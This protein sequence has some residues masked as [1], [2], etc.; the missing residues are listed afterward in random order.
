MSDVS[1][2][3][4]P[5]IHLPTNYGYIAVFLT[6]DCNLKCSY[7][8]NHFHGQQ[9][10]RSCLSADDWIRGLNRLV[11]S[12]NLP[13]TLQGGEPTLHPGFYDIIHSL[14]KDIPIDIL[15]NLQF[16]IDEFIRQVS[17]GR[18]RRNAPYAS[19]RA[20]FHPGVMNYKK[21]RDKVLR[22]LDNDFSVGVW[23]VRHP[24]FVRSIEEAREDFIQH[25]IDFREKEFL[26]EYGG[27]LWGTYRYPDAVSGT[28][29]QKV[30]CKTSE[31]IIGPSGHIY[32]CHSY[33]YNGWPPIGHLLDP[34]FVVQDHYRSCDRFGLCNPCDVKIKTN[35][36]QQ[37]GHTSVNIRIPGE[38]ISLG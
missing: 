6:L 3:K 37:Y 21:L 34:D 12:T 9:K 32:P 16:D 18:I 24:A 15:T 28:V 33:L 31:L 8:I 35:R 4:P 29:S 1:N 10:N 30:K 19:I 17:P 7:C 27:E 5:D 11:S 38:T 2:K 14:R 13:I 25:G 23:A 22:L 36:F 26:G 20:S